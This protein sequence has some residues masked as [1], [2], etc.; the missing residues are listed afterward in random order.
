MRLHSDK[1]AP[2]HC[3]LFH[4]PAGRVW[5][6]GASRQILTVNMDMLVIDIA[7]NFI[8]LRENA[9][10]G[11]AGHLLRVHAMHFENLLD[12]FDMTPCLA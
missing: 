4:G 7:A 12:P 11:L 9:V 8:G 10:D 5:L 6:A 3:A 2:F 1:V